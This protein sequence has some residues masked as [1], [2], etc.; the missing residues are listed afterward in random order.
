MSRRR[1]CSAAVVA[2]TVSAIHVSHADALGKDDPRYRDSIGTY[3]VKCQVHENAPDNPISGFTFGNHP[4]DPEAA[5]SDANS[6]V[7][8]FG[9]NHAKRHCKTQKK[10]T[11]RGAYTKS[12]RPI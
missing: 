7:S 3:T 5:E 2:L 6:F 10:Y 8:K 9:P 4:K 11:P 12:K 1:F